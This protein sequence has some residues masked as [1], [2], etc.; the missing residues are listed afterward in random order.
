ML[1][2]REIQIRIVGFKDASST[3]RTAL[4]PLQPA[5]E[6]T[7]MENVT[8]R[9]LLWRITRESLILTRLV[10]LSWDRWRIE[11]EHVLSTND[12]DAVAYV[13]VLLSCRRVALIHICGS[14]AVL[15]EVLAAL[16]EG[17]E[18]QVQVADYV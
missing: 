5:P 4:L 2:A 6:T 16:E 11:G 1:W 12:A 15:D 13:E 18:R 3:R 7:Q 14:F 17:A 10:G 9:E 8:T